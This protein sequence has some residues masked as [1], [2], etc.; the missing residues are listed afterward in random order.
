MTASWQIPNLVIVQGDINGH[1]EQCLR[2]QYGAIHRGQEIKM[3]KTQGKLG[4]HP[5]FKMEK[6]VVIQPSNRCALED[7]DF[8]FDVISE[9]A[10]A[11]SWRKEINRPP[12][13]IHKWWAK[14][15]GTVF[16]AILLGALSPSGTDIMAMFYRP[17]RF[18]D[19]VVF[20]PFMGS[21][22]TVG[23]ALKLGARAIGRDINPVAHFLVKNALAL[24]NRNAVLE[25]FREIEHDVAQKI[26]M[27][28]K[29]EL[30]NSTSADVL[31]FFWVK[32]AN[33][34]KCG[35]AV[36]LFSSRVFAR[37][38][39]PKK[40]PTAHCTCPNCGEVNPCRYDAT[41]VVCQTCSMIFNPQ[42]GPVCGQ[43]ATCP[44][45]SH[46]FP[47]AKTIREEDG[48]PKHRMYVKLVLTPDG[49]KIYIATTEADQHLYDKAKKELTQRK[50][51]YP[52]VRIRTGYNTNQ[53]LGYNY[54]HWHEMFNDRQ[55][56]CLSILA[57]RIREVRDS[58][59]RD[60]FTCL[61]SGILEFNNMFAS[62]KG[63]GTGAVRHMFANHILKP[64]K[65]PLEANLWGTPKSSGSF[66][67]MFKGRITRALDYAENPFELR[68]CHNKDRKRTEKVYGLSHSLGFDIASDLT[69]FEEGRQVYLSCG[70]SSYTDLRSRSVD[71]VITDP[72]FFDNVHYSQLAD[73]FYVWQRHILGNANLKDPMTTRRDTEVQHRDVDTFSEHL[74]NVWAEMHRILTDD[75]VLA[76][77]YHHSRNEG[78]RSVLHALM[79]SKFQISSTVPIKSEMSVAIPKL[80]AKEP[81][82]LDI[83]IVCRK[84]SNLT[85]AT[86][87]EDRW[88]IIH[89]KA[90]VQLQRL[91]NSGRFLSR[92]D[93]RIIVM[94]QII[95][96]LS[97]L[98]NVELALKH[99]DAFSP[100]I[101]RLIEI[102][103]GSDN[104]INMKVRA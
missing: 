79:I 95:A 39:Y 23:E 35:S 54:K 43:R 76:F 86:W 100:Q 11:E 97:R 70:D 24:H 30:E 92:N 1:Q 41:E 58:T 82:S 66:L 34:P 52:E 49:R 36:D 61:F 73:F 14:R 83:V 6:Q 26:K 19:I 48:P 12:Y 90:D 88:A 77:T 13:H 74:S 3:L 98:S 21:G 96:H 40:Y 102:L 63:E 55:L 20:D 37:H 59:L 2:N 64:E 87:N 81:I 67:T 5:F 75:G 31:Y 7:E 65:V 50:N 94:A 46:R 42:A 72:P 25:T 9:I 68:I 93:I 51:A 4:L 103:Y 57:E 16:R 18:K 56:L 45:C 60:L 91:R 80:Q 44:D 47:I 29:T 78:W 99:L 85:L 17:V 71:A 32:Q 62:Y 89:S 104:R 10:E 33:C 69:S 27:Y 22:T 101:E 28:Y 84:R 38:T 53:A 8:P 15:L